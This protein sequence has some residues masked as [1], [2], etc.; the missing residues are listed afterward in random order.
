MKNS[1]E[2]SGVTL[3]VEKVTDDMISFIVRHY[4][5]AS[6]GTIEIRFDSEKDKQHFEENYG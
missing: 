4:P 1:P 2:R 5:A 3:R 6:I